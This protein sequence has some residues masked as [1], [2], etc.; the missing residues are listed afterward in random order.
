MPYPPYKPYNWL[1]VK[2]VAILASI[3]ILLY[4]LFFS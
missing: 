1:L 4:F 2:A 3:A